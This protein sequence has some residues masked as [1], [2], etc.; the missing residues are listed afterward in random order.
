MGGINQRRLPG[1]GED[2]GCR[3]TQIIIMYEDEK[4]M[5]WIK[6]KNHIK[7]NRGERKLMGKLPRA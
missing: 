4:S 5:C 7:E 1:E 2:I 3:N 6:A